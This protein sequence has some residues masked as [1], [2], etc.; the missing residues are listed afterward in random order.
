MLGASTAH[1]SATATSNTG[2]AAA[3]TAL[4]I[5]LADKPF[6]KVV[7]D[8]CKERT[9]WFFEPQSPDGVHKTRELIEAWNDEKWHEANP[10]HPFAYIKCAMLNRERLVDKVKQDVPLACIRRRGRIAFIPLNASP[11]VEGMFLRQL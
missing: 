2:L 4:G 10:E 8:G 3:L 5:P 9:V 7:E 11:R 1:L 6:V